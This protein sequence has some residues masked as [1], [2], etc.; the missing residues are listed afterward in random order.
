MEMLT[1]VIEKYR[2]LKNMDVL[3]IVNLAYFCWTD[4]PCRA[5]ARDV[6]LEE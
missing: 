2:R 5:S 6:N 4:P 3:N 1:P